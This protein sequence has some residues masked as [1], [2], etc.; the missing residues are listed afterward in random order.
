MPG[1]R[2]VSGGERWT[3]P[4]GEKVFDDAM[5]FLKPTLKTQ[6]VAID[7]SLIERV[8]GGRERGE[9]EAGKE[10]KRQA[11][12]KQESSRSRAVDDMPRA[13]AETRR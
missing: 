10:G 6:P 7:E 5:R 4:S 1:S 13:A 11:Q 2:T 8:A 3:R 9:T 12:A